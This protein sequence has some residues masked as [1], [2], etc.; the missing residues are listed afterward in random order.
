MIKYKQSFLSILF[1]V[2]NLLFMIL[3]GI[4]F[5]YPVLNVLALSLSDESIVGFQKVGIIPRGFSLN[6]FANLLSQENIVRYYINT[7]MYAISGTFVMLLLTSLLAYT[8]TIETFSGKKII[9]ILL[10]ITYFFSG[11][12]IPYYLLISKLGIINTIWAMILPGSISAW[13]VIIFRTFFKE[14][15]KSLRESAHI[16]GAN[17]FIVLFRIIIPLSKALLATFAVFSI[18]SFW[19]DYFNALLFIRNQSKYPIQMLLRRLLINTDFQD[20]AKIKAIAGNQVSART[21]KAA[22]VI[23]TILPIMCVYP[24]FQKYFAKGF[25][26]GSIKG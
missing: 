14:I 19:N 21:L 5:L 20:I 13:N 15:P 9:T 3:L 11:G 7:I 26:I 1:D 16:D 8:L 25:M 22:T 12:L 24:F 2:S 6:S 23:I 18:V 4:I 17:D 10:T